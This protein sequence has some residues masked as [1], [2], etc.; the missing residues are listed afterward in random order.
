MKKVSGL[1][2]RN[3]TKVERELIQTK[4]KKKKK[5]RKKKKQSK[6]K[7]KK[8]LE[9]FQGGINEIRNSQEDNHN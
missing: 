2:K 3:S 5:K 9:H 1:N 8:Q 6:K 7:Q 4:K